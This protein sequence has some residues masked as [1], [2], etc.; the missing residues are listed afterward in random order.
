VDAVDVGFFGGKSE[1][2]ENFGLDGEEKGIGN[3]GLNDSVGVAV[4]LSACRTIERG[5]DTYGPEDAY[6][7]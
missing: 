4:G 5:I 7:S 1:V 6:W 2:R 3:E